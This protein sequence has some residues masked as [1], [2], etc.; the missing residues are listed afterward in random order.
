MNNILIIDDDES[1]RDLLKIKFSNTYRI[2]EADN[3]ISGLEQF[4][5]HNPDLVI[6]DIIM[7]EE[8]GFKTIIDIRKINAEVP[9]IAIT[10]M[11][12]IGGLNA[13]EIAKE[14]GADAGFLKPINMKEIEKEL[15]VL[16]VNAKV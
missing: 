4:K 3:G 11:V 2:I 7:P 6:T 16:L 1:V 10:G 13:L 15:K 9:I 5:K 12:H 8:E 14:F